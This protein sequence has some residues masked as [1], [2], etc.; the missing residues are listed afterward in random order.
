MIKLDQVITLARLK[1]SLTKVKAYIDGQISAL[2]QSVS[3]VMEEA[4]SSIIALE[5]DMETKGNCDILSFTN[6]AVAVSAWTSDTTYADY[7]FRA[8]ISCSGVTANHIPEVTLSAEDADSR[9]F[10][11]VA[12]SAANLVY[13]YAVEKPT[14]SITVPTIE[15][16]KAV[17]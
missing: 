10:A 5:A 13:I 11:P 16:R 8:A 9:N 2:A 15:C 1:T 6:K 3:D 12:V 17:G 7:P 4:N 14:A